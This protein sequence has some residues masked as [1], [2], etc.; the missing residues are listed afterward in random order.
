MSIMRKWLSLLF[1]NIGHKQEVIQSI[2][3][4]YRTQWAWLKFKFTNWDTMGK[5]IS[6]SFTNTRH[7]EEVNQSIIHKYRTHQGSISVYHS[8]IQD[9]LRKWFIV[10]HS[11][12]Q[13]TDRKYLSL[14]FTNTGHNEHYEEVSQSI[15]HKYRTHKGSDSQ[16]IIHKYRIQI[17]SDAVYDLLIHN[18]KYFQAILIE[19]II[20]TDG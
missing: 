7:N 10:Y 5:W 16:S 6:L 1:T 14:S 4:K 12:I 9:T 15:I 8:Q 20:M 13:D 17:G 11:Q 3:Y 2:I 18:L 19:T